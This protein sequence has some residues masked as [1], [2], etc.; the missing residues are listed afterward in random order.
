MHNVPQKLI[1]YT[2]FGDDGLFLG[3]ADVTLPKLDLMTST[4]S[5]SGIAGEVDEPTDG[6]YKSLELTINWRT[7]SKQNM[8]LLK[9]KKHTLDIRAAEQHLDAGT[10][11]Y[12]TP[13][14]KLYVR[15]TCKTGDFGKLSVG[16]TTDTSTV[17]E[18]DYIKMTV[19]DDDVLE[20]D[21]YNQV[22][23][24]DGVDSLESVR[25][26]LGL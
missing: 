2:I 13:I 4:I 25:R 17:M 1:N 3:T 18:L 6:H 5:G 26:G 23:T 20:I 7:I 22:N 14:V 16:N 8:K 24:V 10:G 11:E 21:K 9:F 12:V 15:G 19:D